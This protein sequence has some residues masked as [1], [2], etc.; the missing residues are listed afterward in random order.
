MGD[1]SDTQV[2]NVETR[3]AMRRSRI[4]AES[5]EVPRT[6]AVVDIE[7]GCYGSLSYKVRKD[8]RSQW[9]RS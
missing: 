3:V 1:D 4:F 8:V 2:F 9:R 7:A 6:R 5:G